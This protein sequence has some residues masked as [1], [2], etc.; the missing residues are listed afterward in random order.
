M[1]TPNP[2]GLESVKFISPRVSKRGAVMAD[3]ELHTIVGIFRLRECRIVQVG[4]DRIICQMPRTV[5]GFT[6]KVPA[7]F[8]PGEWHEAITAQARLA[9]ADTIAERSA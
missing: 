4:P 5:T 9:F 6:G 3:I 1:S 8:I 7:V 2:F